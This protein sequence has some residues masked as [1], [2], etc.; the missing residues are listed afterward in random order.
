[1]NCEDRSLSLRCSRAHLVWDA[2][3]SLTRELVPAWQ[4]KN[5]Y[6]DQNDT[7]FECC[8]MQE[9]WSSRS[10]R[11]AEAKPGR[12]DTN[13]KVD[14]CASASFKARLEVRFTCTSDHNPD[15]TKHNKREK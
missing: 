11:D 2:S 13:Q 4:E 3:G 14:R 7:V 15:E 5:D 6:V 1:M 12:S 9:H 8:S 10:G